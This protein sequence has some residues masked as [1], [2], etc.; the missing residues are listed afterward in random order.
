MKSLQTGTV[1][2]T[3]SEKLTWSEKGL[4]HVI[5]G[6]LYTLTTSKSARYTRFLLENT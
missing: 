5:C 4:N 3:W 2:K 1:D 6:D